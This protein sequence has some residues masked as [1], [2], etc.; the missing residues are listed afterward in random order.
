MIKRD[1]LLECND[2]IEI[3]INNY[4]YEKE[5]DRVWHREDTFACGIAL[6]KLMGFCMAFEYE[7]DFQ[8]ELITVSSKKGRIILKHKTT[9][10]QK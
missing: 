2:L 5:N 8:P 6:G 7:I 3:L 1:D 4:L 9:V 10:N